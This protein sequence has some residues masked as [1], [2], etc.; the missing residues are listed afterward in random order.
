MLRVVF[1]II[2]NENT[3]Q[4]VAD[5]IP[6]LQNL[7]PTNLSTSPNP[8]RIN[9]PLKTP[10]NSYNPIKQ[11]DGNRETT[12]KT[13]LNPPTSTSAKNPFNLQNRKNSPNHQQG[14]LQD[15]SQGVRF[16]PGHH[17]R[18][19]GDWWPQHFSFSNGGLL[20]G[21]AVNP[22]GSSCKEYSY[23]DLWNGV[24]VSKNQ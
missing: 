18:V 3:Q 2:R 14:Q 11:K 10:N 12:P 15:R 17:L 21:E 13:I 16:N 23:V 19:P 20:Y 24:A 8:I 1:K 6:P 5:P 22:V 7:W 9:F 4:P